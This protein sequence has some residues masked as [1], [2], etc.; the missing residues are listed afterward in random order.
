MLVMLASPRVVNDKLQHVS[1]TIKLA[2]TAKRML[3]YSDG[4]SQRGNIRVIAW[5]GY[6]GL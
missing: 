5:P 6:L 4:I 1:D 3:H 2:E